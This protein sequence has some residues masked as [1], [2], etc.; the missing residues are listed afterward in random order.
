VSTRYWSTQERPWQAYVAHETDDPPPGLPWPLA[1]AVRAHRG[2]VS[3]LCASAVI[4]A[5]PLLALAG[6]VIALAAL[7]P[8]LFRKG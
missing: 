1:L 6:L 8:R 3:V 5:A 4:V 2:L 7:P